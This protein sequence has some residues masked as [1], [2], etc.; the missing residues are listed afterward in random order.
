M[1]DALQCLIDSGIKDKSVPIYGEWVEVDTVSDLHLD[2]TAKRL[3]HIKESCNE[4]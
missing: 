1:T 3:R 4:L 2:V